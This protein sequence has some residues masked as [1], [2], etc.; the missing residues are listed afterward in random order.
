MGATGGDSRGSITLDGKDLSQAIF[1]KKCGLVAQE[2]FHWAFLTCRETISYAADLYLMTESEASRAAQVEKIISRMGLNSCA[3]TLVG[4]Q[5]VH[6]LSGGQKRRLSLAVTFLKQLDV[7]FLDEVGGRCVVLLRSNAISTQ[8]LC[9]CAV[10]SK[11]LR[12]DF[13]ATAIRLR[14]DCNC[15]AIALR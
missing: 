13:D 6:G 1:H 11:R 9:H 14:C 3:D 8:L 12:Y 7:I 15:E 2:D 4:N 10:I 5:F